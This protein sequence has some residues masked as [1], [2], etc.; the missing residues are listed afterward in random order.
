MVVIISISFEFE[1]E[2]LFLLRK[3]L[4]LFTDIQILGRNTGIQ[5]QVS[6]P[7]DLHPQNFSFSTLDL[8]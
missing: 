7:S 3:T 2:F 1:K 6:V 4:N 5:P 8:F